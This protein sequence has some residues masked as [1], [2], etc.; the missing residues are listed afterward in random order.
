MDAMLD[1]FSKTMSRSGLMATFGS[2][3]H[4]KSSNVS[5]SGGSSTLSRSSLG[6]NI[7][8]NK[9]FSARVV[10]LDDTCQTFEVDKRAKGQYLIDTVFRHLDLGEREYFGLMFNDSGADHVPVGHSPDV[11]RWLDP[12]KLVRKQVRINCNGQKTGV[13]P[14]ATLYFRVKFYVT[15]PSRL[16]EEFTRYQ[17]YMQVKKDIS[18]GRLNAPMSTICL[19][20]SFVVQSTIGDYDPDT[21]G[22]GYLI[23]YYDLRRH[24]QELNNSENTNTRHTDSSHQS[25]TLLPDDEM[26]RRISELHKLHKAQS[27][28]EAEINFLEHAKRLEMYGIALHPGKDS[29]VNYFFPIYLVFLITRLNGPR[30]CK[31]LLWL[32]ERN[33]KNHEMSVEFQMN[34]R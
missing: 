30:S 9:T 13:T 27:P 22:S 14:V 19:L 11:M 24:S 25:E 26:D 12:S 6:S 21:C 29:Q 33:L 5:S 23:P 10:F 1:S 28:G 34:F 2:G 32:K 15:D 3:N 16:K 7:S 18:E 31:K 17:V 8:G 4:N 20:T